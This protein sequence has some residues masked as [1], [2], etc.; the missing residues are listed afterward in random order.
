MVENLCILAKL[1]GQPLPPVALFAAPHCLESPCRAHANIWPSSR[2]YCLSPSGLSITLLCPHDSRTQ[3][4]PQYEL[5]KTQNDAS[6]TMNTSKLRSFT[7][8]RSKRDVTAQPV[9]GTTGTLIG[10]FDRTRLYWEAKGTPRDQYHDELA[11]Q[12]IRH[13]ED[14]FAHVPGNDHITISFYMIGKCPEKAAPNVLIISRSPT[15]R[16]E[17]RS[18]LKESG[19][20]SNFPGF[21][22]LYVSKDPG[23]DCIVPLA[24]GETPPTSSMV[25]G[26]AEEVYFEP[27]KPI[28]HLGLPIYIRHADSYRAATANAIYIGDQMYLQTVYH[29]FLDSSQSS[30]QPTHT[31]DDEFVI[32]TESEPES[33]NEE[34]IDEDIV[35]LTSA[36]SHSPS[37]RS[38]HASCSS[39][40][41][42]SWISSASS[43][44]EFAAAPIDMNLV[45]WGSKDTATPILMLKE[46]FVAEQTDIP[47]DKLLGLIGKLSESWPEQDIALIKV[48]N[49]PAKVLLVQSAQH[50]DDKGVAYRKIA[51]HPRDGAEVYVYTRS[52]SKLTGVLS[53]T[54]SF[55]RSS[56]STSFKEIFTARLHGTLSNGDCGSAVIDTSTGRTYGHV[57]AGCEATGIAYIMAAAQVVPLFWS[58]LQDHVS[59][60][61][62]SSARSV[63]AIQEALTLHS[64]PKHA[65]MSENIPSNRIVEHPLT[66]ID[67]S[68]SDPSTHESTPISTHADCASQ[69]RTRQ[70]PT[71]DRPYR[72]RDPLLMIFFFILGLST[73]IAH[74]VFYAQLHGKHVPS[75]GQQEEKL[76]YS[77]SPSH[78]VAAR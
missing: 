27:S 57:V 48:V 70:T 23:S 15:T 63:W 24:S 34:R 7:F 46:K 1:A 43:T 8:W 26:T 3:V 54:S 53:G 69:L 17:A 30:T 10:S 61:L 31:N 64:S 40:D 6:L 52:G 4:R 42:E 39:G 74:C 56:H 51:Y 35:A 65:T 67:D 62:S 19:V 78:R 18:V 25:L 5:A 32:D 75:Q 41:A 50:D 38:D 36:G 28:T 12:I 72:L 59:S 13:L 11:P 29:A 55:T 58:L 44:N 68:T 47:Q 77:L 45:L 22:I 37:P 71:Q 60:P 66:I 73:S 20:L 49:E 14:C 9:P 2:T 33:E 16:A 21:R 76:R